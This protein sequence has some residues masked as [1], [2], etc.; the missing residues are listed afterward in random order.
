MH[1]RRGLPP[2]LKLQRTTA[3]LAEVVRPRLACGGC[4]FLTMYQQMG[5]VSNPV[6]AAS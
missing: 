3:A 6:A 4:H 2:S 1:V 5:W